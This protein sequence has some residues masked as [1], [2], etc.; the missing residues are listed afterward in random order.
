MTRIFK[1]ILGPAAEFVRNFGAMSLFFVQLLRH[2]PWTL[3]RR[4]NLVVGQVYNT[5]AMSIVIKPL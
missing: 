3:V 2:S 4:F 5:G 1:E